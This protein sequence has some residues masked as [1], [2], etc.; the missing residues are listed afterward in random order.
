MKQILMIT[1]GGTIASMQGEHGLHPQI[2][3]QQ[4]LN[5]VP[6]LAN[7]CQVDT[8]EL[9]NLDST[10]IGPVQWKGIVMAIKDHYTDYDGFVIIHGTDTMAYSAAALSYMIRYPDKPIVLTG[11]QK[12]IYNRDSD[13]RNN[14]IRAFIY[15]SADTSWGVQIVFDTSVILGTRA[16]KVKSKSFNAF[17]SINYPET[18]VF[19]DLQLINFISRP[20]R[21]HSIRFMP[22]MNTRVFVLRLI[23]GMSADIFD[24]LMDKYDGLIIEGFGVG[25]LPNIDYSLLDGLKRWSDAGHLTVFSTQVQNEGSDL[26]IYE[27]G[28]IA[29]EMPGVLEAHDMTPEAVVTKLMWVLGQTDNPEEAKAMFNTPMQFDRFI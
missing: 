14:L 12:S 16:R 27:V 7:I 15:A 5:Y 21:H 13:A 23:P 1:T 9:Y 17:S 4:L 24:F 29:S 22:E 2:Q 8:L 6:E 3:S 25:G 19:R 28:K 10:N 26:S 20:S 11:S 18:A